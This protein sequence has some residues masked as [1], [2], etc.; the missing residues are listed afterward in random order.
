M[1]KVTHVLYD[2]NNQPLFTG[3][4]QMVESLAKDVPGAYVLA[5]ITHYFQPGMEL[6]REAMRVAA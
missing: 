4:R 5:A 6:A 2:A 1:N 3:S